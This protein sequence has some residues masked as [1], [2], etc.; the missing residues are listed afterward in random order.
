MDVSNE[1]LK[2][3][4]ERTDQAFQALLKEPDSD[5]LSDAYELARGD[6]FDIIC[7]SGSDNIIPLQPDH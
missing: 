1:H 4:I 3:L 6:L 7:L 5:E 2:L